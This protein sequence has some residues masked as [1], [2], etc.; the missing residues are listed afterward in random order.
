[1]PT[2]FESAAA[3]SLIPNPDLHPE[4]SR[5]WEAGINVI[6]DG[7]FAPKDK[8]MLKLGYF[9]WDVKDYVA[10]M[11]K[12]FVDPTYGYTYTG[13][14]VT[15]IDRA[16]FEDWSFRAGMKTTGSPRN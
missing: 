7:I 3:Y 16:R 4:R 5:N 8:A 12:S 10:R 9:N 2:L 1:M 14:Q 11:S 6:K 13:L 15:N